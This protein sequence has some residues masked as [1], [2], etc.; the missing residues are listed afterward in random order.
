MVGAGQQL[1][2]GHGGDV[3]ERGGLLAAAVRRSLQHVHQVGDEE[4]VLQRRHALLRQDGGLAA[5][6]ARQC[7]AVGRDVVLQAPGGAE[8]WEQQL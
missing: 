4:V 7:E 3:V 1:P 8:R 2:C 6:G 5:H